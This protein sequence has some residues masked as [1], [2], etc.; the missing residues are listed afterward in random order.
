MKIIDYLQKFILKRFFP[1]KEW[2]SDLRNPKNLQADIVAGVTV[3]LVLVPQSM[4]YAQLA[5]LPPYYGLYASFLPVAIASIFG[6]SRQLATGPVAVVSLLTAAALEPIASSDPSGY[7]AYAIMLAFLVGLFQLCLGLLRLGVLVDF[8]SHPVVTGFTNAAAIIIATSQLSK[9]FG[10]SVVTQEH[11]Y[12]TIMNVISEAL[13]NTHTPT[14]LMGILAIFI[15]LFVKKLS[16]KYPAVLISV[17]IT[18]A[19]S[20]Y[21]NFESRFGGKVIGVVPDGLPSMQM[22]QIDFSQLVN[23]GTV[24]IAIS[25]IGFMEAISIA[26][27]MATQT[28]QRLDADQELIGQGLSNLASSFFQGYPVSGSFSRSAVNISAGAVTGFS[29]VVTGL[30]VGITLLFL[31]PLLYHLPQ[32]T[33]AAVIITAVINLIKFNPIKYA[34]KVQKHD[35]II[36]VI[37]FLVTL[38]LAPELEMGIIVGIILSLGSYCYRS[39]RPRV[40]CL[41]KNKQGVFRNSDANNI[42]KCCSISVMRFDGPLIFTNAGHFENEVIERVATKPEL[43]Y[44]IIDAIA[45]NEIDA[46]GQDMLNSL[47]SRLYDQNIKLYFARVHKPIIKIFTD[48]GYSTGQWKTH[49]HRTIDDAIENAWSDLGC[50]NISPPFCT[51]KICPMNRETAGLSSIYEASIKK[52]K[53]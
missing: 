12:Q 10:V 1:F 43:R 39:M 41:S 52:I 8:L 19:I 3:A 47:S 48:T 46:S 24:A 32:A 37:T 20:W 6:S 34:W 40:I 4:A 51:S 33:L 13:V 35:A 23:L 25:L 31:T 7:V 26:K 38:L 18:T 30:V 15:I 27:A 9:L 36:S 29:S 21:I 42:P 45:I 50:T 2:I 5:G 49:F 28:K 11:H 44:F 16:N 53:K 22:P 14:L 17:V